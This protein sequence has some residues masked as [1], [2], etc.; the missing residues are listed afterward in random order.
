MHDVEDPDQDPGKKKVLEGDDQ[1]IVE[2]MEPGEFVE[3]GKDMHLR[4]LPTRDFEKKKPDSVFALKWK[5]LMK[6]VDKIRSRLSGPCETHGWDTAH[7]SSGKR[8]K[9]R[10]SF[11]FSC[12]V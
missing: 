3:W 11:G 5:E 4:I 6:R 8:I 9:T 10:N 12:D 2:E 7:T 1:K